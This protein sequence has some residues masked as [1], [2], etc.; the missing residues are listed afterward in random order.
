MSEN[1]TIYMN[2]AY[3]CEQSSIFSTL[4]GTVI[5]SANQVEAINMPKEEISFNSLPEGNYRIVAGRI[6]RVIK[7][8]VP[9]Q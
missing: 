5:T 1:S 8:D 7:S 9:T 4:D 2:A 6:L 3:D